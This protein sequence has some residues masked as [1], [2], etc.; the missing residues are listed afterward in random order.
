[1]LMLVVF[2]LAVGKLLPSGM[3][4]TCRGVTVV[5]PGVVVGVAT[6]K[7]GLNCWPGFGLAFGVDTL[8][9]YTSVAWCCLCGKT[10][11]T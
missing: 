3:G 11:A 5:P 2:S 7:R 1:M 10:V 8:E 6:A 4:R 9:E